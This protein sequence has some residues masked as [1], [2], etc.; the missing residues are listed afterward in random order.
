M[1]QHPNENLEIWKDVVGY[2]G[3]YQ[4]SNYGNI[5]SIDRLIKHKNINRT[6]KTKGKIRTIRFCT[7]GYPMVMLC[8][9][10]IKKM[11]IIHRIVAQ[12]FIPNPNNFPEVN[13]KDEDKSNNNVTNLEWCTRIYNINYGTYISRRTFT[14]QQRECS[15]G[16]NNGRSK[17]NETQVIDIYNSK[18][19]I[20]EL[21][22]YFDV[23][24][25]TIY[26]I[27]SKKNMDT[28]TKRHIIWR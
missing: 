7:R 22:E 9:N 27:K 10:G 28:F 14:R 19:S 17:L 23:N 13:H 26:S 12:A 21:A 6:S 2:E 8:K 18:K 24:I 4:V 3:F 1:E 25:C 20:T 5:K 15:I 11:K 16:I